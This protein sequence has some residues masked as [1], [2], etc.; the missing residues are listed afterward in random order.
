MRWRDSVWARLGIVGQAGTGVVGYAGGRA[1]RALDRAQVEVFRLLWLFLP[2]PSIARDLRF[3]H[4]LFSRFLSEAGQQTLAFGALVAVARSGGSAL[5][6]AL[7]GVAG[8]L[9]P[10]LLGLYG[11]VVADH[12]PARLALAGAYAGQAVLCFAVPAFFD[13]GELTVMILLLLG[14][15]ALAQVSTPTEA[16]V[17]PLVAN[18]EQLASAASLIGLSQA[19]GQGFATALF[20]PVLVKAL[21]AE[22]VIYLTGV[23][24]L[25]AASRVF[26]LPVGERPWQL[27][28][29][30]MHGRLRRAIRWLVR[31]PAVSS[32][33]VFAAL[34]GTVNVVL[35]T[36]APRYTI[37]VLHTDAAN[38]AYV[39]APSAVGVVLALLCAP[40]LIKR[41][42]ERVTAMVALGTAALALFLLG[43]IGAVGDIVDPLNPMHAASLLGIEL[44]KSVRTAGLLAVPIGFGVTLTGTAVQTYINRNVPLTHQGRT[45]ALQGALRNAT[46][47]APLLTLGLAAGEF[48]ADKVLLF[49][50]LVLLAV[51]YALVTASF[52][53]SGIHPPRTLEVMETFWEEPPPPPPA[54]KLQQP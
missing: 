1:D 42:G 26:D 7:V 10:A 41:V 28:L 37:A 8:L 14:F 4:L 13:T 36:L 15:N 5:D 25:L 11:G 45:F 46:A 20:A 21:G 51:A 24:M 16:A 2:A 43:G 9:P 22:S 34:A 39:F 18:V 44:N 27:R 35:V 38:T 3:Q 19:I 17:L 47:I 49:S 29:P 54:A 48:G 33:I 32:M 30:P 53:I 52:R 6:V 23:L 12:L 40:L 50:P 31:H